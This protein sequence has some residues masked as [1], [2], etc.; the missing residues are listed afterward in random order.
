MKVTMKLAI[1]LCIFNWCLTDFGGNALALAS[2]FIVVEGLAFPESVIHDKEADLYLVSN[3]GAFPPDPTNPGFISRVRPDGEIEDL[4]WIDGL[5]QPKGLAIDGDF[6]YVSDVNAVHLYD[7]QDGTLLD[8]W[9]VPFE[10]NVNW[11]NDVAVGPEGSV[12]ATDSGL[13]FCPPEELIPCPTDAM[14]LYQFDGEGNLTVLTKGLSALAGP[15]G[16]TAK[17]NNLFVATFFSNKIYRTNSSGKMFPVA[18][19]PGYFL[20]GLVRLTDNS[21]LVSSWSPPAIHMIS[22]SRKEVTTILDDNF[23]YFINAGTGNPLFNFAPAD[24]GFDH[25]RNRILIPILWGN[26]FI[27]YP[28]E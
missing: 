7:R 25:S 15:N 21:L 12:Y 18:E 20:D 1:F 5:L 3:F 27:I 6:L 17:G 13:G 10:N 23:D 11:L 28:M 14:A 4:H 16:I 22:P 8:V 26:N 19:V 2:E 24:I 9:P